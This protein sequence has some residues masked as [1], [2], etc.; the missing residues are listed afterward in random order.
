MDKGEKT[1]QEKEADRKAEEILH[2][3]RI[4][5]LAAPYR[6]YLSEVKLQAMATQLNIEISLF[7]GILQFH[8]YVDY[9]KLN[10]YK[11]PVSTLFTGE[12]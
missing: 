8:G 9:R 3:K 11:K 1:K 12:L 4:L 2:V 5:D 7:L 6:N 10:K